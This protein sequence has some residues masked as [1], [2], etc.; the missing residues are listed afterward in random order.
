MVEPEATNNNTMRHMLVAYWITKATR[1]HVH[2]QSHAPRYS[3]RQKFVIG[4]L[5]AF[6]HGSNGF[7]NAAQ[8]YVIRTLLVVYID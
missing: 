8:C 4:L 1:A 3:H 2:A 6:P 7:A 5:I